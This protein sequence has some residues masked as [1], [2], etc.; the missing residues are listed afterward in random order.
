VVDFESI[1]LAVATSGGHVDSAL[2]IGVYAAT[3]ATLMIVARNFFILSP[4]FWL[5]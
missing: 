5:E 4:S 3:T 1:D 2:A